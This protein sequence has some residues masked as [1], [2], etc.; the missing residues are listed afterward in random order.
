MATAH[1]DKRVPAAYQGLPIDDAIH[2]QLKLPHINKT[3]GGAKWRRTV[4]KDL[5]QA[6]KTKDR[7][8]EDSIMKSAQS[9]SPRSK[10]KVEDAFLTG[11]ETPF[12]PME[13][14]EKTRLRNYDNFQNKSVELLRAKF[15]P[16]TNICKDTLRKFFA[17]PIRE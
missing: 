1:K 6:T 10:G 13:M 14:D 12:N 4:E 8:F 5:K 16:N 3:V 17:S 7:L 2:S 15:Q 9:I 11:A